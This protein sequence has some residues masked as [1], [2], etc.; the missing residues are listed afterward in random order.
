[1]QE[2]GKPQYGIEQL[3]NI[4]T[5]KLLRLKKKVDFGLRT[6]MRSKL[7]CPIICLIVFCRLFTCYHRSRKG[8]VV[9][10]STFCCAALFLSVAPGIY[11]YS[12]ASWET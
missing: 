7:P 8:C 12:Q 3:H 4:M 1:M 5:M 10:L 6:R 2:P 9:L 11:S